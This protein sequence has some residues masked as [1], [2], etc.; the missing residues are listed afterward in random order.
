[1][2]PLSHITET[3]TES[4]IRE[5]T[6][7]CDAAGGYNL[8]QGFPDFDPPEEILEA[9]V[10][11]MRQGCNQYPVTFGEPHFREAIAQKVAK[12][13]NITCDP[14]TDITVTCGATEAMIATLK[15]L[16]NPGDEVIIFEP[17]YENYGPDSILS[18]ATPRFVTLEPG[19]WSFDPQALADAFNQNTKAIVINT[20]NNPTGKVFSR[21]ELRIIADLC[22]KWDCYCVADE[23]YEHIIYGDAKHVSMAS[24]EGMAERTVTINSMSKSYSVTGWRVG[25][26]IASPEITARIRKVHDF[27]TVGAPTPFQEAGVV[28]MGMPDE[29]YRDLQERYSVAR[30]LVH[31]AL[32]QAGF[33]V[34]QPQGAYYILAGATDL[35]RRWGCQNDFDF[36]HKLIDV[37]GVATVPGTSF[38]ATPGKGTDQVRF[39]FSKSLDMLNKV[40]SKLA[41]NFPR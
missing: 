12:H 29:Y 37:T 11:A 19:E 15:A 2:K 8:S 1:M 31:K 20:P 30:E 21:A 7:I 23:V 25:W 16:V 24:L 32:A 5:M 28:A 27:L 35:M 26:A 17:F 33:Q 41:D 38:Y 9:A 6:R 10:R 34:N 18:G 13:N 36:S 4:V 39:C 22:I 14:A 40:S 3:F